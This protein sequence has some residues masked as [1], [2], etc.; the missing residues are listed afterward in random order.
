MK[1]NNHG[2]TFLEVI[3]TT[4]V[5]A[6]LGSVLF[7][8]IF[9][10]QK[11]AQLTHVIEPLVADIKSQQTKAMTGEES[12]G[13]VSDGYGVRF[14][15]SRYILFSGLTYNVADTKNIIYELE[16]RVTIHQTSFP[17]AVVVFARGSGEIVGYQAGSDTV[18]VEQLDSHE[19]KI[20]HLNRYG[21][22][23]SIN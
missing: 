8:N 19:T 13:T 9:G 15:S 23:T 6:I 21:I 7:A 22:I 4:G 17:D 14:E 1:R 11:K 12:G 2:F 20:I 5:V 10:S 16:P 3:V 18:T